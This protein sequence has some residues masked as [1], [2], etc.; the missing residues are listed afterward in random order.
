[1][2]ERNLTLIF[3]HFEEVH[4]G[5]DVFLVP[6]YL[7]KIYDMNVTIVCPETDANKE[8]P[9]KIRGVKIVRLSFDNKRSLSSFYTSNKVLSYIM[10]NAK[11]I[12]V[13]MTFHCSWHRFLM[14]AIYKKLN[15]NGITYIK[16]DG[17]FSQSV[18]ARGIKYK[19]LVNYVDIISSERTED[20]NKIRESHKLDVKQVSNG[21]DEELITDLAIKEKDFLEKENI[22]LTVGRLGTY[23]KNTDLLLSVLEDIDLKD[24]KFYLVGPIEKVEKDFQK[25][26]DAFF[27]KRPDLKDKVIFA[28]VIYDKAE[29]WE[30]YN[31]AKVFVLSSR[32]ESFGIVLNEAYRFSNY[33]LS[34]DVGGAQE[35]LSDGFGEIFVDKLD[36]QGKLNA[37]INGEVNFVEKQKDVHKINRSWESL[38]KGVLN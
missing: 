35:M 18:S 34:T 5:K 32:F 2:E 7:G 37:I 20:C 33:I 8:M 10:K 14:M 9:N 13:L 4:L 21:F 23:Q 36:L 24:W 25:D 31:R 38:L 19:Y 15:K 28:G 16:A 29:L 17:V 6:Y 11:Y 22:I 3:Y 1:M 30:C 26:I 12:D 27:E